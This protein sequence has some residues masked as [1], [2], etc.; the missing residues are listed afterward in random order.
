MRI[1]VDLGGTKI[2]AAVLDANSEVIRRARAPTPR[3]DY[4]GIIQAIGALVAQVTEGLGLEATPLGVCTP[5]SLS[6]ATGLIRNSNTVV[7]NGRAFPADL[8]AHLGRKV[9]TANDADCLAL[10]EATDGAAT[11]AASVFG[12]IL[13]TGCGGGVVVGGRLLQGTNGIAGEWGHNPLP[14]PARDDPHESPGHQCWCGQRG[15]QELY[16]SGT[17]LELDYKLHNGIARKGKDIVAAADDD[18]LAEACLARYESR[19]ARAL[20]TVINLLD[21]AVIVLG[22]GLSNTRRLYTNLPQLLPRH[23]FSDVLHT[24]IVQAQH[25]D[26]SGVRGAAWLWPLDTRQ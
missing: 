7:M 1:G 22:G 23:V 21:P 18:P 17:G 13:G 11:G 16:L 19:L 24:R 14:W 26:A 4:D 25:G 3:D 6:P 12:A 9:R 8:S 10:S 5:G 20:A 2:E 15:C